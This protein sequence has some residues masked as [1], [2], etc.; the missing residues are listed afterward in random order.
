MK[1]LIIAGIF[2]ATVYLAILALWPV[3]LFGG[4]VI[5]LAILW[6]TANEISKI[7]K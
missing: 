2:I 7:K 3:L 4:G 6:K 1:I 5:L